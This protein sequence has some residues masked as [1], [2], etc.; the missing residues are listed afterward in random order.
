MIWGFWAFVSSR[1]RVKTR[2][3]KKTVDYGSVFK[4][5]FWAV[6]DLGMNPGSWHSFVILLLP[7]SSSWTPNFIKLEKP[8][9]L[10]SLRA[11]SPKNDK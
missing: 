9:V 5:I 4:P 3:R 6:G 7:T 2:F 1:F 8:W 10:D 11:P